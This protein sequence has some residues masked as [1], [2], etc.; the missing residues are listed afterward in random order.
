MVLAHQIIDISSDSFDAW[1]QNIYKMISKMYL[2]FPLTLSKNRADL[3]D[4]FS[5]C[6]HKKLSSVCQMTILSGLQSPALHNRRQVHC[7]CGNSVI[8]IKPVN[9]STLLSVESK[10]E[11]QCKCFGHKLCSATIVFWYGTQPSHSMVFI[12]LEITEISTI[13]LQKRFS[14]SIQTKHKDFKSFPFSLIFFTHSYLGRC[15]LY[16]VNFLKL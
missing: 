15:S 3:A 12:A 5:L 8:C 2:F 4:I 7:H 16:H 11:F 6:P 9:L 14:S 1:E 13:F 10:S